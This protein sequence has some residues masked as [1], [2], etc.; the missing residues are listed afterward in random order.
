MFRFSRDE[1]FIIRVVR[2]LLHLKVIG[3]VRTMFMVIF[4]SIHM[5]L[6]A[7]TDSLTQSLNRWDYKLKILTSDIFMT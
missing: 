2:T 1:L 6:L 3:L 7:L 5:K 4:K